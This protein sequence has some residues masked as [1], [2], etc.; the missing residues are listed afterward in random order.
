[1]SNIPHSAPAANN[2]GTPISRTHTQHP[3][4][5]QRTLSTLIAVLSQA[6]Y[7]DR[8][9]LRPEEGDPPYTLTEVLR[10]TLRENFNTESN[11]YFLPAS[12]YPDL[13]RALDALLDAVSY[14]DTAQ[15]DYLAKRRAFIEIINGRVG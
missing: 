12:F 10:D 13:W 8:Y 11:G 14:A 9:M 5:N 7:N 1:M 15:T 3:D 6:A 4:D 2:H